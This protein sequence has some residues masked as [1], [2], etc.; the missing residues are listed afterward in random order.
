LTRRHT[1][2]LVNAHETPLSIRQP[3][4]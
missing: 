3:E 1:S 2:P 4:L